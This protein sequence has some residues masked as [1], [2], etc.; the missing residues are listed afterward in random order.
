MSDITT[1]TQLVLQERQARDRG[2]WD[3]MRSCFA[4]ADDWLKI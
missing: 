1:I 4:D 3:R 2:W